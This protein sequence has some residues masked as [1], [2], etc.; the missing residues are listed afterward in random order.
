MRLIML[1]LHLHLL[2]PSFSTCLILWWQDEANHAA[3]AA[4][5]PAPAAAEQLNLPD[6]WVAG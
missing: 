3:A 2:L 6:P 4:A 5:A 1:L